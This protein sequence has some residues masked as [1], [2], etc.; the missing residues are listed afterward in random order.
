[1]PNAPSVPDSALDA[2]ERIRFVEEHFAYVW[3]V[4][5]RMGLSPADADDVSQ[6]TFLV[7]LRKKDQIEEGRERAFLYRCA[8]NQLAQ[9]RASRSRKHEELQPDVVDPQ[10]ASAEDLL[11]RKQAQN[12]L[13]LLLSRLSDEQRAVFVLY[14]IE[15]LTLGEIAGLLGIP[16]G[17]VASRLR[18]A[19][20]RVQAEV[21]PEFLGPSKM[22]P[23]PAPRGDEPILSPAAERP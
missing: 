19:R 23:E 6:E 17:T 22:M 13:D 3:R 2:R 4:L 1:V 5:R 16:S 10:A 11:D 15:E 8:L 7:G 12:V 9:F 14:E 21:R 20:A 18:L